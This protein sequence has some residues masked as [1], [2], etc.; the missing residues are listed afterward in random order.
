MPQIQ[1]YSAQLG[2]SGVPQGRQVTASDLGG[3]TGQ[4]MSQLGEAG[5]GI[6]KGM[7]DEERRN[8]KELAKV[9]GINAGRKS[10][11]EA[12]KHYSDFL[13][14]L[15]AK[16]KELELTA[17]GKGGYTESAAALYDTLGKEY[18]SRLG[19]NP[20]AVQSFQEKFIGSRDNYLIQSQGYEA[21]TNLKKQQLDNTGIV[22]NYKSLA[23]DNP[24]LYEQ[25]KGDIDRNVKL[26]NLNPVA[27][28][29]LATKQK[30]DLAKTTWE[31]LPEEQQVKMLTSGNQGGFDHSIK[32]VMKN[33]GGY[34]AVD[35]ASGAPAIYGINRKWHPEAFDKAAEITKTEGAEAGKK[36][37]EG[38]YKK[39]FWDR[40]NVGSLPANVQTIVMD[41]VVNHTSSFSKRLVEA[42]SSESPEALIQ[43]RLGEYRRLA[44]IAP[45][46]YA[47]SLPS[48]E[49]R[50]KTVAASNDGE[51]PIYNDLSPE[52]KIKAREGAS[53]Y[54]VD[55]QKKQALLA[56]VE[57]GHVLY[58]PKRIQTEAIDAHYD[59]FLEGLGNVPEQQTLE[60]TVGYVQ[61]HN[62]MPTR[63]ES[64]IKGMIRSNNPEQ[65]VAAVDMTSRIRASNPR[66][67]D[68]M[69]EEELRNIN[70]A[71][72]MIN[73]GYKPVDVAAKLSALAD[74]PANIKEARMSEY[75]DVTKKDKS[76]DYISSVKNSFWSSDPDS[77]PSDMLAEFEEV[78]QAEYQ[79]TGNME[80]ARKQALDSIDKNWGVS[81]IS[82]SPTYKKLAPEKVYGLQNLSVSENAEWIREQFINEFSQS[83]LLPA[84]YEIDEIDMY[85]DPASGSKP[86]YQVI[87]KSPDGFMQP[88]TFRPEW[89]SSPAFKRLEE[90]EFK[91]MQ[92]AVQRRHEWLSSN[93]EHQFTEGVQKV[94]RAKYGVS[95]ANP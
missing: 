11:L 19:D 53:K 67:L 61:K 32:T 13:V 69:G 90:K 40:Y 91:D 20:L 41:G 94:L 92:D 60:E 9:E 86:A 14:D 47:Q 29:E 57:T 84:G 7:A 16:N 33:E 51:S 56:S 37:A 8:R 17:T 45:E 88:V 73:A 12:A 15:N 85:V 35:G 55:A 6:A 34:T 48:W 5:M 80:V 81:Y 52:D 68:D 39:E 74:V 83:T 70:T 43:M 31:G 23:I 64:M 71:E 2:A 54:L 63:V 59:N 50:L 4:A 72:T 28:E 78:A 49:N 36:Y 30:Q 65:L 95:N 46:K 44:E 58:Q 24:H 18:E 38:F 10:S 87:V 82:G 3:I 75:K 26:L 25:F 1:T 66:I 22:E 27:Q 89:E 77:I 42:A 79:V 76:S 62:L 93:G 21:A